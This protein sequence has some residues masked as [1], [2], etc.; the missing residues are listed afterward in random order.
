MT[1]YN[2]NLT[3]AQIDS[4]LNKVHNADTSP[5]N[6][7]TNMVTSD[8]VHDAVNN[9]Q[10]ANL[11]SN[12]VSTDLSSGNNNTTIPTTQAVANL[13]GGSGVSLARY[14]CSFSANQTNPFVFPFVED[15]DPDGIG[16][17]SGGV[18]TVVPGNYFVHFSGSFQA[19][20]RLI[21]VQKDNGALTLGYHDTKSA[22]AATTSDIQFHSMSCG[23][24]ISD[25]N[26]FTLRAIANYGTSQYFNGY[27]VYFNI[28]KF[29]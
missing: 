4:A 11:N 5:V 24:I 14:T 23:S 19:G 22:V 2:L 25:S 10:F 27:W 12:L 1:D 13:L 16:S 8:G 7:S 20:Q 6:G 15:Y 3:G 18:I 28:I 17:A 9:I 21:Y 26:S 29:G